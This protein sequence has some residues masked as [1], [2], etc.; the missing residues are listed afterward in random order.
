MRKIGIVLIFVLGVLACKSNKNTT[1]KESNGNTSVEVKTL[2]EIIDNAEKTIG[3]TVYIKGLVT[4]VCRFSG[5]RCFVANDDE[6]LS[7]R[8]EAGGNIKG[9]NKELSGSVIQVKGI[10]QEQRLT[11]EYIDETEA[12]LIAEETTEEGGKH[13]DAEMNNIK[14]MRNWMKE[15]KKNYYPIYF[16]DGTD[17]EIVE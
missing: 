14:K 10:L 4:H 16:I 6:T 12:K 11:S 1:E 8:I 15:H 7:I 3:E 2:N 17:Y 9:F 13:C 5:R